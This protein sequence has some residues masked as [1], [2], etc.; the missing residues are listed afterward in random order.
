MTDERLI[1]PQN[2]KQTAPGWRRWLKEPAVAA[3][4]TMALVLGFLVAMPGVRLRLADHLTATEIFLYGY[5]DDT[6]GNVK[7]T[8]TTAGKPGTFKK[9]ISAP[10]RLVARIFRGGDG[11]NEDVARAKEKDAQKVKI[12]P[13][14][15][16]ANS[17]P[18]ETAPLNVEASSVAAAAAKL[19]DDAMEQ[20]SKGR[21]DSA[22][23]KLVGSLVLDP[24]NSEA[25][26][27]LAVCYDEKGQYKN[28]QNE[29][30][31]ALRV[32]PNNT[33]FLN[34]LG[35][36]FYLA[37]NYG[38]SVKWYGK[39]LQ[40]S[41]EDKRLHNNIGLAYGRKGEFEKARYHFTQAV[42]EFGAYLNLGYVFSQHGK[43]EQAIQAYEA[44][45]QTQPSSLPALSN[46][47][48]L[49]ERTG[50]AREAASLNE[51]Y[52]KLAVTNQSKEAT[53][54]DQ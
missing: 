11:A 39:G 7:P 47:A 17:V 10:V 28:A 18:T 51:Q 36:S 54:V 13:V 27:M 43:Y 53:T 24:N 40:V 3:A 20:H 52:K 19:Y 5:G 48:Q 29:Y 22:I 46:L 38:E 25:Y 41:P 12:T 14:N 45:L 8:T 44:A 33:R 4:L 9:I 6:P 35:Y 16:T 15:R 32:E 2:N 26:N 23:E 21:V 34:N 30:K 31:K 1:N 50:R 42:G 49:Y 37:G